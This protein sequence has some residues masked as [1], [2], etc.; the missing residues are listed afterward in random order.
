M[1]KEVDMTATL[2][3]PT[4]LTVTAEEYD[5]MPPNS[6]VELVDGV[7]HVMTPATVRHQ[8]VVSL[9]ERALEAVCPEH[10]RVLREQEMRIADLHR[11]NP[12]LLVVPAD[13]VSLDS[14]SFRPSQVVLAVEVVSPGTQTADRKHKPVEYAD[15][16]V[17]H[18]WRVEPRPDLVVVH[19]YLL[20][21]TGQYLE[22][23]LFRP[24]DVTVVPGLA[25]AQIRVA[26]LVPRP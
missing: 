18:Y 20:G 22:T 7:V 3:E 14:Y 1:R 2:I 13:E 8:R 25:W 21:E 23:G 17:P 12:D 19:T 26:E 9:L 15:A 6:R 10:L 16:D 24:G 5:A 11:R 4:A